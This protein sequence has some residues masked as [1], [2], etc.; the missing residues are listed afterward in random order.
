MPLLVDTLGGDACA[1]DVIWPSALGCPLCTLAD[2]THTETA[3][4]DG[5][6]TRTLVRR[7][8]SCHGPPLIASVADAGDDPLAAV[9]LDALAADKSDSVGEQDCELEYS[10]PIWEL[11]AAGALLL[12]VL[13][14]A[15]CTC[16]SNRRLK[17]KYQA[18][19]SEVSGQTQMTLIDDS[20]DDQ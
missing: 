13:A 7:S 1:L 12:L 18:L 14:C 15:V 19:N 2:Y 11:A 3:C 5:R 9:L 17:H 8:R 6:H 20:D 16:A 10:F 4:V